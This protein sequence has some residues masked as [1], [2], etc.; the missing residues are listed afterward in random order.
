MAAQT[1]SP[2]FHV[3]SGRLNGKGVS[4][5]M[6]QDPDAFRTWTGQDG[7]SYR[8]QKHIVNGKAEDAVVLANTSSTLAREEWL[9]IDRE[10]LEEIKPR[11]QAWADLRSSAPYNVPDAFSITALEYSVAGP[12]SIKVE[13][14]MDGNRRSERNRPVRDIARTPLPII[15]CDFSFS[16]REIAESRRRGT[17]IDTQMAREAAWRMGEELEKLTIGTSG[18]NGYTYGPGTTALYGY[19]TAPGR[20][21]YSGTAPTTVGWTP[22]QTLTEFLAMFQLLRDQY[23]AGPYKVYFSYPW[24]Q[25]LDNDYSAAY[26]GSSLRTR[27]SQLSNVSSI[28]VLEYLTGFQ[29]LI[30]DMSGRTAQAIIGMDFTT[31]QWTSPD[32]MEEFFKI[33]AI[34]VPRIR[35]NAQGQTGIVHAQFS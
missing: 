28:D 29:V 22:Q 15:H 33:I 5:K 26:N 17:P 18:F 24:V 34:L 35:T 13:M 27:L 14:S 11:L 3:N 6:L 7:R 25:Y 20:I 32:T 12:N 31:I 4:L 21:T 8:V 9:Q 1:A 10:I 30:V 2:M 19:T 23:F 16:S